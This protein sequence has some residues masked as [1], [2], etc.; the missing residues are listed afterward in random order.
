MFLIG[1]VAFVVGALA[2]AAPFLI[3]AHIEHL[4]EVARREGTM[5][6][7]ILTFLGLLAAPVGG[8]IAGIIAV[9]VAWPKGSDPPSGRQS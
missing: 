3:A 9:W 2:T 7:G 5:G 1:A 4:G 6:P 8:V